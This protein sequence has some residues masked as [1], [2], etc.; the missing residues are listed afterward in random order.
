MPS[1]P[2]IRASRS[3]RTRRSRRYREAAKRQHEAKGGTRTLQGVRLSRF[4][5]DSPRATAAADGLADVAKCTLTT[6]RVRVDVVSVGGEPGRELGA[7]EIRTGAQG[8]GGV[9]DEVAA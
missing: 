5:E 7:T 6:D 9:E 1:S 8:A 2:F 4:V 3:H